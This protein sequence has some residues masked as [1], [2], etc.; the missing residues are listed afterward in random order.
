M[1]SIC[2][3]ISEYFQ[4]EIDKRRWRNIIFL[5]RAHGIVMSCQANLPNSTE[6]L[7]T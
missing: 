1:N 3:Y 4:G 6:A 7:C 2:L 5:K